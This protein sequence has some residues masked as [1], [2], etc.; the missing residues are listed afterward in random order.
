MAAGVDTLNVVSSS[1]ANC[2]VSNGQTF[3]GR[4]YR[5]AASNFYSSRLQNAEARTISNAG[6]FIIS[7]F[8]YNSR[9][10][11]YFTSSQ[12]HA[13]G[14]TAVNQAVAAGQ[15]S[16]TP[17]Y[18]TVD[19]DASASDLS[20]SIIPYLNIVKT[21]TDSYGYQLGIYGGYRTTTTVGAA[22]PGIYRWQASAWSSGQNDPNRRLYQYA[23]EQSICGG[24]FDK[25]ESNGNAGGWRL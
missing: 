14:A 21:Y 20:N 8:Q 17:I 1:M 7:I 13:D 24:T 6:L 3:V 22:I 18:F 12:A 9:T 10:A 11:S 2:L 5:P 23:I 4:Y 15:P 19:Y 25:N 16:G